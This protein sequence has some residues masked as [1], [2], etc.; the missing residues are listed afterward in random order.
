MQSLNKFIYLFILIITSIKFH[1]LLIILKKFLLDNIN[2]SLIT[3]CKGHT[4]EYCP[5]VVQYFKCAFLSMHG[6]SKQGL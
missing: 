5:E 6:S 1:N 2:L 4:E 3:K